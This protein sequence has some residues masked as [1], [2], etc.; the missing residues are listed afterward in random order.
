MGSDGAVVGFLSVGNRRIPTKFG[1]DLV[2]FYRVPSNSD[3][4]R[5]GFRL[6]RI[7]HHSTGSHRFFTEIV[8]FRRNPTRIRSLQIESTGRIGSHGYCI[9]VRGMWTIDW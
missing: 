7:D 5:V 2:S 4:I 1:S 3:E 8:G 9:D 6:K